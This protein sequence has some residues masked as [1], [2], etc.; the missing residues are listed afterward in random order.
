MSLLL[1]IEFL[2]GTRERNDEPQRLLGSE[3]RDRDDNRD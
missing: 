2:L 1:V 3:A